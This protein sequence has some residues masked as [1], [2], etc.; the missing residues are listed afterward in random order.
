MRVLVT[1]IL[2]AC[3]W[4]VLAPGTA[5]AAPVHVPQVPHETRCLAAGD[6]DGDGRIDLVLG[7]VGQTVLW[8]NQGNGVFVEA[9]ASA[10]PQVF[11]ETNS[12][13]LCDFDGDGDLDLFLGNGGWSGGTL[14]L[15]LNDGHGHFTD[16][17]ERIPQDYAWTN[18]VAAGDLD[19][20]GDI[21]LLLGRFTQSTLL[22]NDGKGHFAQANSRL[23]AVRT[24]TAVV[25]LADLD[26]DGDL[27]IVLGNFLYERNRIWINDGLGH[28]TD[29]TEARLPDDQNDTLALAV[30]DVDGDGA[31]DIVCGNGRLGGEQ[32]RLYHNDGTG[33]FTD[34]T[35]TALPAVLCET[36]AVALID[37]DGDGAL[38]LVLGNASGPGG[39][40]NL[41][42]LNDGHGHFT[43]APPGMLPVANDR[44]TCLLAVDLDGDGRPE[45]VVG[46]G[47]EGGEQTVVIRPV[48][49]ARRPRSAK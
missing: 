29:E 12:L 38:D 17:S 34:V 3:C 18:G 46:N 30:G 36:H 25:V 41:L 40:Q 4:L 42:W 24:A 43:P 9:P 21:D 19:G 13:V 5:P 2:L 33:H 37:F 28:F 1:M 49:A 45:L 8:M 7:N 11:F 35:S 48:V 39:A 22:L 31:P 10:T 26:G 15:W 27:D 16:A 47:R 23:P 44:T 6:L 32:T 20:D 14:C